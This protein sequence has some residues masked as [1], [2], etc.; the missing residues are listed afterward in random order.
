MFAVLSSFPR[1]S[2]VFCSGLPSIKYIFGANMHVSKP[3]EV[4]R[5]MVHDTAATYHP[6]K[7]VCIGKNAIYERRRT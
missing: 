6:P 1:N 2:F 7:E 5:A 4:T 3:Y